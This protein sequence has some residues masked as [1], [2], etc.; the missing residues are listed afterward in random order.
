MD[1]RTAAETSS[2][3]TGIDTAAA[4]PWARLNLTHLA[5][6]TG[7]EPG[8]PAV[9]CEDAVRTY[10]QLA[11]RYRR[12]AN[13]LVEWGIGRMDR[14][15]LT[16]RNR[17]EYFEVELGISGAAAIMVAL[18]WRLSAP[19]RINLLA[20]SEARAVF[21][22][23]DFVA[24]IARARDSGEL[25]TLD[26]IVSFGAVPGA[27][28]TYEQLCEQASAEKPQVVPPALHDPH[29]IIYTSGTTGMPKGAVWAHG[30]VMWN[31][32]QQVM[33]FNLRA[34]HSNYVMLDL[35]YIGGRHDFT[36]ALLHQ[37]GTVHVRRSGGFD[38][39]KAVDYITQNRISHVLWVPT[40]IHDILRV[41][42]LADRDTTCLEMIMCGGA[43]LSKDTITQAQRAFPH[44]RFV[45]VFG[46]TEGGGTTTFVPPGYLQSKLGSA[47]KASMHN[48][49]EIVDEYGAS[50]PAEQIGEILV[51]GPALTFGYWGNPEATREA[52]RDG[53]LH[54]GDLG[55][56]DEDAFL[57]VAGRKKDMIIS[58]GMNIY[59]SEVEDV[60][61]SFP[62]VADVTVIGLPDERW[63]ERVCAVILPEA[64]ATIDES[65]VISYCRDRLATFK[66]P[67]TVQ[68]VDEFPRTVSGKVQKHV[69]RRR[70]V[71]E[72]QG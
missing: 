59:P 35:N 21:A 39:A 5:E 46:L 50:C 54:T 4:P 49:I 11:E 12:V 62:G 10:A 42:G 17:L 18:S 47:G 31:S 19:E 68:V 14:V 26:L 1:E 2:A 48:E 25:P 51:R 44:T 41:P 24:E 34:D 64:G 52:V 57:Y 7:V 27:D 55:Y 53:W 69:L 37:G 29:E 45:Q 16:S 60:L 40:M 61:R 15:G 6:R 43:P 3:I 36:W 65:E 23:D 70:F 56:L 58:G 63:G 66:K 9:V 28:L 67:S 20:R 32:I 8:K 22:E 30:T 72:T 13:T 33:D 71:A 38:A